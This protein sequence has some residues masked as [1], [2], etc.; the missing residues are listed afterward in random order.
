MW[1]EQIG[2]ADHKDCTGNRGVIDGRDSKAS[3]KR[4]VAQGLRCVGASGRV[5]TSVREGWNHIAA[6]D[7]QLT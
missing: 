2:C 4:G 5:I 1:S 3:L 7:L 6:C